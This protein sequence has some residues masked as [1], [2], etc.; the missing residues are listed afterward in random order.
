M[1]LKKLKQKSAEALADISNN[2]DAQAGPSAR[3]ATAPGAMAFMQPTIDSLSERAET[4]EA[5]V[6]RLEAQLVD[7]PGEL[8]IDQIVVDPRR[9]R[10]LTPEQFEELKENLKNN[11]LVHPIAVRPIGDGQ[12]ELV[13]G[14]NR[15]EA[16]RALGR[17]TIPVVIREIADASVDRASFYANLLQPELP[18]FEKYLGFREERKRSGATQKEM[19]KEAGIAESIVSMLFAFDH[20]PEEA[21]ALI[22]ER[23]S[24]IGMNCVAELAKLA[25]NGR[26]EKVVEAV[27][28]LFEGKI[29]QKEAVRMAARVERMS[30]PK[31]ASA[32][33]KIKSGRYEFCQYQSRGATLRI[34]F[35][36]EGARAEAE[37]KIAEL[38]KTLA[39]A[40]GDD[41]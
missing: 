39:G 15:L 40:P 30:A 25:K 34:D 3:P 14:H 21:L 7:Q 41:S 26:A 20:L 19:A 2:P 36:E 4:A 23:P 5:T 27:Q 11:P 12:F 6:A 16:F 8:P 9:K 1:S 31:S 10:K 37:T 38:L 29:S 33:V 24:I 35:R 13:S 32:P 28:A 22:E 17:A 18:D